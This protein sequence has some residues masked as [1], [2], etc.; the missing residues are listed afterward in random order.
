MNPQLWWYVARATGIVA[1]ALLAASVIWGLLLSTRLARGRPTPAWLLDLHRFLGGSAV[2]FTALH[3][4]GLVA[5]NYVDFGLVDLLLPYASGWKPGPVALGIVSVYLLAVVEVTRWRC[6]ASPAGCGEPCTSAATCCSGR[7]R[8]TSSSPVPM[9]P[10]R[11]PALASTLSPPPSC[12]SSWCASSAPAATNALPEASTVPARDRRPDRPTPADRCPRPAGVDRRAIGH[13]DP[14][15][16]GNRHGPREPPRPP[17]PPSR[18]PRGAVVLLPLAAAGT[19]VIAAVPEPTPLRAPVLPSVWSRP[20]RLASPRPAAKRSKTRCARPTSWSSTRSRATRSPVGRRGHRHGRRRDRRLLPRPTRTTQP[21]E[22][23]GHRS[24]RCRARH[25]HRCHVVGSR[26]RPQRRQGH[27]DDRPGR[28]LRRRRLIPPTGTAAPRDLTRRRKG[29]MA[30]GVGTFAGA[31][32]RAC[33][34]TM[35]SCSC[36]R[37]RAA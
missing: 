12:S 1:W 21:A 11:S 6:A 29:S 28:R 19:I 20:W 15:T 36:T 31:D 34:A 10:T 30:S 33:G 24:D 3:L 35:I 4:V 2:A 22:T 18:R 17:C 8:S 25:R 27:L 13:L 26:R 9:P 16:G 7:A 23:D 37:H 14:A 5:D 32:V